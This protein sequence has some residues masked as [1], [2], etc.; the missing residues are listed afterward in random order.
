MILATQ[1]WVS[2]TLDFGNVKKMLEDTNKRNMLIS[3]KNNSYSI[4]DLERNIYSKYWMM[5]I[6]HWIEMDL[7][8]IENKGKLHGDFK[9]Y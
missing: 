1:V 9:V 4:G 2:T 8:L 5:D 6:M 3:K 7:V